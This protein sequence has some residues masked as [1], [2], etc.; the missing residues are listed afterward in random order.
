MLDVVTSSFDKAK[1]KETIT[2][3][4]G[5]PPTKAMLLALE[6][7]YNRQAFLAAI[8]KKRKL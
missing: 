3:R 6:D 5:V 8:T 1:A 2:K 7:N 4:I